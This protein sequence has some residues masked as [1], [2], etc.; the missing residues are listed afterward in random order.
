MDGRI[1]R[2]YQPVPRNAKVSV[3]S[4]RWAAVP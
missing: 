3:G 1:M 4:T 2:E